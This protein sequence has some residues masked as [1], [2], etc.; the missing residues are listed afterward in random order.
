MNRL[1]RAQRDSEAAKARVQ[2]MKL[3][4]QLDPPRAA[5]GGFPYPGRT[6]A[7][8]GI[9]LPREM[10]LAERKEDARKGS[11]MLRKALKRA[12]G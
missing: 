1:A 12:A 8:V 2:G 9:G 3:R 6:C 5:T 10:T 4:A 7:E 11:A